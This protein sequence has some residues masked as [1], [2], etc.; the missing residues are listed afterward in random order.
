MIENKR[1]T[2]TLWSFYD[3]ANK[4]HAYILSL[5][6]QFGWSKPHKITG[7]QVAD[8][9]ALD[10]WLRGKHKIGQSPILKPLQDMERKELSR[11]IY[12]LEQM[13]TKK[14]N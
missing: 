10:A 14:H 7:K 4:Q 8:L 5:C 3:K 13:V 9:G 1:T 12:A 2:Y 6:I 11:V